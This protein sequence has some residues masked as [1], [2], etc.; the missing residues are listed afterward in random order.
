[1]FLII[2]YKC[3]MDDIELL[4]SLVETRPAVWDKLL[5][6]YK[7]KTLKESAWRYAAF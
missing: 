1:M 5:N 4:I 6:V 2:I 3:T 7:D